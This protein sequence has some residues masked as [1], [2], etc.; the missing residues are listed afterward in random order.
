MKNVLFVL[1]FSNSFEGSFMRSILALSEQIENDNG[2][3]VFLIPHS[4]KQTDWATHLAESGAVVYDFVDG[5]KGIIKNTKTVKEIIAKYDIKIIHAHFCDYCQHIPVALA[6][7]GKKDI[8]YIV[9]VH[10]NPPKRNQVFEKLATFFINATVYVS[11]SDS[12]RNTL[13]INGKPT[14]TICNA[15]DFSRLE[16]SDESV[17]KEDYLSDGCKKTVLMFGQ[18]FEEKG[19]NSVIKALMEYDTEHKIQLLVAVGENTDEATKAIKNIC[20]DTPGWIKLLPARN[21]IATYFNLADVFVLANKT[22]GSPYTMIESAYLGVP[23]IYYDVPGQNEMCIPWSVKV[24][25]E[26]SA[27][28]YKALCEIFREDKQET[29]TMGL[30]SKDY[31]IKNY[32]LGTWVYEI[33]DL[34][35]NVHRM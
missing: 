14:V 17:K 31:V 21:D 1:N 16:F 4:S 13:S 20:N 33:I 10:Q 23:I 24:T 32:S 6:K 34:Y 29:Y 27:E 7:W 12:I 19:V 25:P 35:K 28:L 30:E 22:E 8:D 3:V 18:D 15:V 26:D 9:H 5:A 2:K 11:V